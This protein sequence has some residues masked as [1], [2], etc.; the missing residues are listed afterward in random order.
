MCV[1]GLGGLADVAVANA[2]FREHFM[3]V[4]VFGIL[5]SWFGQKMVKSHFLGPAMPRTAKI[6]TL[7][8][9]FAHFFDQ[10]Q[11]IGSQTPQHT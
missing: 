5:G 8:R 11:I 2:V 7:A 4:G 9:L 3:R 6:M 10:T 1:G